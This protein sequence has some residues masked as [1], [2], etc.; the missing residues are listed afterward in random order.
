MYP[1]CKEWFHPK[2]D[3]RATPKLWNEVT[4]SSANGKFIVTGLLLVPPLRPPG[5]PGADE[6]T[7]THTVHTHTCTH[8]QQNPLV[9]PRRPPGREEGTAHWDT[10]LSCEGIGWRGRRRS[11]AGPSPSLAAWA[12]NAPLCV[13]GS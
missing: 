13:C 4:L 9:S 3:Q 12:R 8:T 10:P 2:L 7:H 6:C 11:S 5:C 1:H